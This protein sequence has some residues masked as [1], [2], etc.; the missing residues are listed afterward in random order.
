MPSQK[1]QLFHLLVNERFS[2]IWLQISK[3]TQFYSSIE[4]IFCDIIIVH[5]ILL[6]YENVCNI[7]YYCIH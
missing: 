2:K 6:T 5:A 7:D 4:A 3:F 1:F